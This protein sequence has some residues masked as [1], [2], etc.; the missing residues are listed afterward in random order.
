MHNFKKIAL[1]T[2]TLATLC[3][4]IPVIGS[5]TD[6]PPFLIYVDPVTGKYTKKK[7]EHVATAL[8]SQTKETSLNSPRPTPPTTSIAPAF[9]IT[10]VL[11]LGSQ[12]LARILER[13]LR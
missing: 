13:S 3:T 4:S 2:L 12:V 8:P 7:P 6:A 11:L 1:V 10:G 9:L 5:D